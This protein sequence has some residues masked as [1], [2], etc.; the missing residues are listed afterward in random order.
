MEVTLGLL[1]PG[2]GDNIFRRRVGDPLHHLGVHQG[3][4][5]LPDLPVV[6]LKVGPGN[7][8]SKGLVEERGHIIGRVIAVRVLDK[9]VQAPVPIFFREGGELVFEGIL[10]EPILVEN[11][12][13]AAEAVHRGQGGEEI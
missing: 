13:G 2:G 10:D 1:S 12:V 4:F 9:G 3:G 8:F 7:P 6:G 5:E 11:L